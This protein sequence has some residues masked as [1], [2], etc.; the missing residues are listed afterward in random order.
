MAVTTP[1]TAHALHDALSAAVLELDETSTAELAQKVVVQGR[2]AR[3]AIKQ[4]LN[5][6]GAL[7]DEEEFF[8]FGTT[9]KG[10]IMVFYLLGSFA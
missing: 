1:D 4:G 9:E 2:G 5:Q 10:R 6:A 8:V 3:T 7:F